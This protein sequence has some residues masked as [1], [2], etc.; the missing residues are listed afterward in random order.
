MGCVVHHA[1]AASGKRG[2]LVPQ[3]HRGD[4]ASPTMCA[5]RDAGSA[6]PLGRLFAFVWFSDD[7]R[8]AV[9]TLFV[10]VIVLVVIFIIGVSRRHHIADEV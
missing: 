3:C 9:L 2:D 8:L 7:W 4:A 10:V 5:G 6:Q 1:M